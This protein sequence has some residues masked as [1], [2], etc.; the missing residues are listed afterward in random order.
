MSNVNGKTSGCDQCYTVIVKTI[1]W[2]LRPK[3]FPVPVRPGQ[4]DSQF[5]VTARML[6][7]APAWNF[8]IG[9]SDQNTLIEQ[10]LRSNRAINCTM[11]YEK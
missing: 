8:I 3:M 10:S 1:S 9:I 6:L 11:K 4:V 2:T 7:N 5:I